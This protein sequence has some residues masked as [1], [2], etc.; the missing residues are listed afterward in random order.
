MRGQRVLRYLREVYGSG[1]YLP[2]CSMQI[3]LVTIVMTSI[4]ESMW[5]GSHYGEKF[6]TNEAVVCM[7]FSFFHVKE[8]PYVF[9]TF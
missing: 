4:F 6:L 9:C 8:F 7:V 3:K 2:W 5:S 1:L